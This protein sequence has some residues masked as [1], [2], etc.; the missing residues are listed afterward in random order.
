[1]LVL[2]ALVF[3]GGESVNG[4]AI[5]LIVGVVVGTYSSVFTASACALAL[6]VTPQDLMPPEIDPEI[7]NL[8]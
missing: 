5:A 8:P 6:D 3:L 4:F 2:L 7:D 1:L